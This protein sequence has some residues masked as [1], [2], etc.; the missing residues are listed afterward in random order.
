MGGEASYA[1]EAHSVPAHEAVPANEAVPAHEAVG[2]HR[3][4][5][6]LGVLGAAQGARV[7][8]VVAVGQAVVPA[9]RQVAVLGAG[10]TLVGG[11]GENA[12]LKENV[13]SC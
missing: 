11:R 8:H 2:T 4:G 9:L 12:V 1:R 10:N 5:G 6:Q 7:L 3:A 13:V